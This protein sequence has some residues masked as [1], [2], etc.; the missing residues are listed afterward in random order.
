MVRS[1]DSHIAVGI[2]GASH[3]VAELSNG[4]EDSVA[5]AIVVPSG[6]WIVAEMRSADDASARTTS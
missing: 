6:A 2:V 3:G 1:A 5:T 4:C